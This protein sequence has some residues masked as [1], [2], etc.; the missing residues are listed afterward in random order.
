MKWLSYKFIGIKKNQIAIE[1]ETG[2]LYK[3]HFAEDLELSSRQ[4][5]DGSKSSQNRMFIFL[6]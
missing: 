6:Y 2:L 4:N 1:A 5:P 3:Y